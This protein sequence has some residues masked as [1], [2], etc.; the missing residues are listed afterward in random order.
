MT[1]HFQRA[2]AIHQRVTLG[3]PGFYRRTV[4][5]RPLGLSFSSIL[6]AAAPIVAP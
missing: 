5:V 1:S 4:D 6:K 3:R 2:L